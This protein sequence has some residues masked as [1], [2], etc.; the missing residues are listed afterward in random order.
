VQPIWPHPRSPKLFGELSGH[1]D[2]G[3]EPT[4]KEQLESFVESAGATNAARSVK[5]CDRCEIPPHPGSGVEYVRT[6][7][8]SV[9]DVG[10]LAIAQRLDQG[11]LAQVGAG[12]KYERNR[13]HAGCGKRGDKGMLAITGVRHNRDNHVVAAARLASRQCEHDRFEATYFAGSNDLN[14]C[15]PG[16]VVTDDV[17]AIYTY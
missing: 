13:R 4:Q 10:L 15:P 17:P 7:T 11:S 5:G 16:T 9:D 2:H 6:V 12:R 14:N 3:V 8:M 1:G